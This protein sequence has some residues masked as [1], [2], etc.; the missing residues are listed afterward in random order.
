MRHFVSTVLALVILWHA[1]CNPALRGALNPQRDQ[2][3]ASDELENT[4]NMM[5]AG[6]TSTERGLQ[7][8]N[9]QSFMDSYQNLN[10]TTPTG[11]TGPVT[12]RPQN[13]PQVAPSLNAGGGP[14]VVFGG[15]AQSGAP[16]IAGTAPLTF[17]TYEL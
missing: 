2:Q 17:G 7:Q 16:G 10:D 6:A 8:T 4:G 5:D 3:S 11:V 13:Q 9:I 12:H 15:G 14:G 1:A